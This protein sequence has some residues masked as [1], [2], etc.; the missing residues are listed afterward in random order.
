LDIHYTSYANELT[1]HYKCTVATGFIGLTQA[2]TVHSKRPVVVSFATTVQF[3]QDVSDLYKVQYHGSKAYIH[4][5]A[6]ANIDQSNNI[7]NRHINMFMH[8]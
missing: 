8:S 6:V 4:N 1:G 5:C 2:V 7:N 3:L